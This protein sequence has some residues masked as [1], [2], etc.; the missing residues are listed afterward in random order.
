MW[1]KDIAAIASLRVLHKHRARRFIS[2]SDE[3][4]KADVPFHTIL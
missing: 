3:G 1:I 4:R 2:M